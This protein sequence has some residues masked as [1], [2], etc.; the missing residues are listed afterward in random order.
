MRRLLHILL[1]LVCTTASMNAI[2]QSYVFAQM[3]GTPINTSGWTLQGNAYTGNTGSNIGNGELILTNPVNFQSGSVFYNV[4][5]NLAQCSKWIAEFQFRIAEGSAADGLAFCYLDVPPVG[6]VAGGGLGIPATANGLKVGIDTWLNCG[7]DAVPKI[8]LRW[9][10]GYDECNGQPTKNNNDGSLSFIRNGQYH[11]CKI[12]YDKGNITVSINGVQRI[13]GFQTFNFLGYF[14]FTAST[15]GSTDRH[16]IK[17]VRIY[18]EMPPSEAGTNA[19]IC[20]NASAQIGAANNTA[21]QYSWSPA[22][23]LSNT[24]TSNPTVTL[25]NTGTATVVQKYYLRTEFA[26]L[27]GCGSTDSVL[28]TVY[29]QPKAD[30]TATNNGCI[31]TP[32]SFV[33]NATA[34]D[35][36]IAQWQWNF[37]DNTIATE[38]LP[39]KAYMVPGDY[40]IQQKIVSNEGCVDSTTKNI[41]VSAVPIPNFRVDGAT[42]IGDS[43]Q[44]IDDSSIPIGSIERWIWDY[45]SRRDTV[46]S[47]INPKVLFN[48]SGPKV[49]TLFVETNTGCMSSFPLPIEV[50][51]YPKVDFSLPEVCLTDAFAYFKNNTTIPGGNLSGLQWTWNFGD[52]NALPG[53][54]TSTTKDGQHKYS[55]VGNYQVQL[56]ASSGV[57]CKDSLTQTLTVNGDKPVAAF[58]F[59]EKSLPQ[60]S[61]LPVSIQNKST[62]NF[63]SITKVIVYWNWPSL[64]DTTMDEN[65]SF[66]KIYT[67]QFAS[68]NTPATKDIS[69]RFV[70]Y[71]GEVCVNETTQILKLYSTPL[72]SFQTIPGICLDALPRMIVQANE[73]TGALG[74]G[75]YSGSGIN[76]AGLFTPGITGAGV[77]TLRYTFTSNA[78]CR[79]SV[80]QQITVW[81]RPT[82][83]FNVLSPTCVKQAVTFSDAS[84]AN[85]NQLQQWQ[86]NFGDGNA[87]NTTT[88]AAVSHSYQQTGAVTAQLVVVT[89]SGCVSLPA[90]RTFQVNA[91]PVVDFEMPI[92]CMP[93][94][95]AAFTNKSSIA[96]GTSAQFIYNWSFGVPNAV[97][98]L[99]D[100]VYNYPAEG[101]YA[102]KLKVTSKDGCSDS[103]TK[104]LT[105][106]YPQPMA[107]FTVTPNGVCV[108][109][110]M[111]FEDQSNPLTQTITN[112]YWQLGDGSTSNNA[113][114]SHTYTSAGT[115][116]ARLYYVTDKGC[117]SDTTAQAAIVHPYPVVNAGPD[118]FVLEGG[119]ATIAATALGSSNYVYRWSPAT[120]LNNANVLQPITKPTV[121]RTYVLTVTGAGGCSSSDDVFVKVLL[122]PVIPNVFSP[123]GDGINDVW[124]IRYLNSYIGASVKVFDRYGKMIFESIGYNTPWDGK[125]AGKELPVGVYY[126][127]IDPKNGRK[128]MSGSVTILR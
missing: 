116:T 34:H 96:D 121:D 12:E 115:Y 85:V 56:V 123:N 65:P 42:C 9:G 89:D 30:F 31:G 33:N 98:T 19:A 118:L 82:A 45:G 5:I 101:I 60:C 93:S 71:S 122:A 50:G 127:I 97:S 23:G 80:T 99:K 86:W 28:V 108:G 14:G 95:T 75:I 1:I 106:V 10:N 35:R 17:D 87:V 128:A 22:I 11:S 113:S 70:A 117:F 81:P 20:S 109:E 119:Q 59:V 61:N 90:T 92:V 74:T 24:N 47:S 44:L 43:I 54:N 58:D 79:D 29:P 2:A 72:I 126:Y 91:V 7:T 37:G 52:G 51:E 67:H 111:T 63:G 38:S 78:G 15:G 103:L 105:E 110:S 39:S 100:P 46:M 27:P 55:T 57:G 69:I 36:S 41:R 21:Y 68:F 32:V 6:F 48:T 13:T 76:A 84:V 49:V 77:H 16:S 62:V 53:L 102:V 4:P 94:G 114:P 26:N 25:T 73:Q 64:T 18:T 3:T 66:D 124:N 88:P 125:R 104:N 120:D 40:T 8:E 112:W 107:N 83:A